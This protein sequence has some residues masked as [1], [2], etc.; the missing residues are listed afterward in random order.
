MAISN[1]N[2]IRTYYELNNDAPKIVAEKFSVAYRT[3]AHWIK[4]E[5]WERGK[6]RA[7]VKPDVIMKNELLQ[8]E[9]FSIIQ[10]TKSKLKRQML[11]NLSADASEL[12]KACLEA[13]LD[14]A[15]D[16]ILMEAMSLDFIQ[17][18]IAQAC[19]VAKAEL[20]KMLE[21][22]KGDKPDAYIIASAEKVANMFSNLQITAY[23]KEPPRQVLDINEKTD[24]SKLTTEQ[25]KELLRKEKSN[26]NLT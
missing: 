5:R 21:Y 19:L 3:L 24:Y 16:K 11:E 13:R 23:G 6:A 17:K 18:N 26:E 22:R 8:N 12:E 7:A 2:E 4:T 20:I 25:L 9:S 14:E 15:S 1:K 10:A